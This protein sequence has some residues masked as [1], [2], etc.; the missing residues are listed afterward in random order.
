[1]SGSDVGLL[2]VG[3]DTVTPVIS[4]YT[5]MVDGQP[6]AYCDNDGVLTTGPA[7]MTA[8]T[9]GSVQYFGLAAAGTTHIDDNVDI[10]VVAHFT[11][12]TSYPV[13]AGVIA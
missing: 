3:D 6:A 8:N 9:I 1:M 2:V 10:T 5:V 13:W 11:D 4:T 12:N 7:D